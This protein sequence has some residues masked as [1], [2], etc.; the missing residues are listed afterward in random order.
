[1]EGSELLGNNGIELSADGKWAFNNAYT[2]GS[3]VR[4]P[5]RAGH[6]KKKTVKLGFNPDNLRWSFDGKLIATGHTASPEAVSACVSSNNPHCDINYQVAEIDPDTFKVKPLFSGSA[7][8]DFGVATVGLKT[9]KALWL[10]PVRG[11]C[12][13]KVDL[14]IAE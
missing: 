5:L 3:L 2:A 12:V 14:P 8:H 7:T 4:V 1:V 10:G 11:H 6:G 13:A 9:E